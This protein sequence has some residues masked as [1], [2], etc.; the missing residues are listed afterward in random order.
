[1]DAIQANGACLALGL[2]PVSI[3]LQMQS[4]DIINRNRGISELLKILSWFWIVTSS[5]TLI[6]CVIYF[7]FVRK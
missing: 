7:I 2:I 6:W 1:M 3:A 5:L 4:K